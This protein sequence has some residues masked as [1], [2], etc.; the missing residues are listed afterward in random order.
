MSQRLIIIGGGAAGY[1]AAIRAAE[2]ASRNVDVIILESSSSTLKKVR[3]SA[4]G[5][6]NVT[7]NCTDLREFC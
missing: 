4:L 1:F 5:R 7:R 6:W 3:I 2:L